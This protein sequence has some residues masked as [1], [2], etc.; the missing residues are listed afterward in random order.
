MKLGKLKSEPIILGIAIIAML[1]YLALRNPD[2]MNY[3]LPRLAPVAKADIGRVDI[4]RAGQAMRLERKDNGWSIQPQGF[5]AD[6][7]KANAIVDAI[8]NLNLTA[9]VSESKN[10]LP[11]GLDRENAIT[12]KAYGNERLL[13]EFSIGNVASTY[14]HTYVKLDVDPRVFHARNSF[15]SDFDQKVDNLRDKTVLQ[16]DKNEIS[17]IEISSAGE[18]ILFTKNIKPLQFKPGDK[19]A[20]SQAPPSEEESWQTVDGKTANG[21]ELNGILEQASRLICEG[22]IDGKT[23]DDFKQP[24][25]S[26]RLK[27]GKDFLLSIF[28]KTEKEI[29]YAALSSESPYPFLLSAYKVENIMKKPA[30]LKNEKTTA[31]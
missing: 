25:Y 31:K 17:A 10:Y 6:P 3:Q 4:A 14:S 5:A 1:L 8:V 28:A 22:F 7:A 13:R 21:S 11:Y 9:L 24:L 15:R 27:G 19:Q 18:K 23:K 30:L 26:L 29:S 20:E 12:V 2:R 16:F